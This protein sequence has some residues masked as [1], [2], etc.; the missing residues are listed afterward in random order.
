MKTYK[1][2]TE[3]AQTV[4][5]AEIKKIQDKKLTPDQWEDFF[6]ILIKAEKGKVNLSALSKMT[7]FNYN[8]YKKKKK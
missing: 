5:D 1:E 2:I 8:Q 6:D 3:S 7:M 4:I